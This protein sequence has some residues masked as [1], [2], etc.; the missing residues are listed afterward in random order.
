MKYVENGVP[1]DFA[2]I[3]FEGLNV[4][5]CELSEEEYM[6]V[7]FGIEGYKGKGKKG[8][9]TPLI[10]VEKENKTNN[11]PV[12]ILELSVRAS[13]CLKRAGVE[14]IGQLCEMREY[15]LAKIRNM[16]V[17]SVKEIKEKLKEAGYHLKEENQEVD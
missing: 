5:L 10:P 7:V 12:D 14:T 2:K 13:N 6:F 8:N 17:K 11:T 16:G 15:D 1:E 9:G 4:P 3:T